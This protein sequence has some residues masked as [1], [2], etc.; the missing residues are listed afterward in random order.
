[1]S[2]AFFCGL[3]SFS[4]VIAQ[5]RV[6]H[7]RTEKKEDRISSTEAHRLPASRRDENARLGGGTTRAVAER[8]DLAPP[9]LA[10]SRPAVSSYAPADAPRFSLQSPRCAATAPPPLLRI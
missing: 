9:A 7:A 10:S 2:R 8:P 1:M 6:I 3:L 4:F 5:V